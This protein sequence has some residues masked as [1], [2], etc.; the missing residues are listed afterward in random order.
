MRETPVHVAQALREYAE[1][2][3]AQWH[4][5]AKRWMLR[6]RGLALFEV[7]HDDGTPVVDLSVDETLSIVRRA[8]TRAQGR[9]GLEAI[10]QR[11]RDRLSRCA[12][13][14]EQD[15][16]DCRRESERVL[17]FVTRGP[18]PVMTVPG[19]PTR[20]GAMI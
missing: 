3:E 17:R 12:L 20:Q 14:K 9:R 15:L 10:R 18:K 6:Y 4:P 19:I 8:D 1:G 11:R 2:L 5:Q 16:E 7:C 13:S